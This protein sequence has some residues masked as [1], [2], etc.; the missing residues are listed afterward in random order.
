MFL[1]PS[2]NIVPAG[3][4]RIQVPS[5]FSWGK[6]LKGG[7]LDDLDVRVNKLITNIRFPHVSILESIQRNL[8]LQYSQPLSLSTSP[9]PWSQLSYW[10]QALRTQHKWNI[11]WLQ[12]YRFLGRRAPSMSNSLRL[13]RLHRQRMGS[14]K[15]GQGKDIWRQRR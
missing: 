12:S 10:C 5:L 1:A 11:P 3:K 7:Y 13:Q 2:P 9:H 6:S 14:G 15:L 8:L 4:G